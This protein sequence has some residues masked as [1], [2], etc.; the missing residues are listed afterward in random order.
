[1]DN[2]QQYGAEAAYQ[3]YGGPA[4]TTQPSL[5]S[6]VIQGTSRQTYHELSRSF[7][8]PNLSSPDSIQQEMMSYANAVR[9]APTGPPPEVSEQQ[10]E[11]DKKQIYSHPLF[12]LLTIILNKCEI[13]TSTSRDSSNKN[14]VC[15]SESFNEDIADYAKQARSDKPYFTANHMIDTL[16]VQAIQ[17]LRLHLLEIEKVHELCDN[18]CAKYIGCLKGKMPIDIMM[19]EQDSEGGDGRRPSTASIESLLEPRSPHIDP[20][21]PPSL[22]SGLSQYQPPSHTATS[23]TTMM[24]SV[25]QQNKM[26]GG[27][28]EDLTPTQQPSQ[29][30]HEMPTRPPGSTPLHHPD[31]VEEEES[32]TGDGIDNSIGSGDGTNDEDGDDRNSGKQRQKK[33][34]IFP[35]QATTAMRHW[36]FQHLNHPY[37]SEEQKKTL[38]DSTGLTILQVNNWFINARRRIVQPMIDKSN[39][40]NR[41]HETYMPDPSRLPNYMH[42]PAAPTSGL[43]MSGPYSP[44]APHMPAPYGALG[45]AGHMQQ[46]LLPPHHAVMDGYGNMAAMHGSG[47][48]DIHAG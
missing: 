18:F 19:E 14:D 45:P 13:A 39:R 38:S 3:H 27:R 29:N 21:R 2:H 20:V 33:R 28:V 36:L 15:S 44:Q 7:N 16:M 42:N 31:S 11:L 43:P 25:G 5:D 26:L 10:I 4:P 17:V 6:S 22:H 37:P 34:G 8:P 1:M 35:K 24:P 9:A 23:P 32:E 47:I 41:S 12:S 40:D 46:M 30:L 48:Q